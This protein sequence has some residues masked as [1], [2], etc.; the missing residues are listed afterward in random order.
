MVFIPFIPECHARRFW[1]HHAIAWTRLRA[2]TEHDECRVEEGYLMMV[3]VH[4]LS[5]SPK[6][7][8][9]TIVG[10]ISGRSAMHIAPTF[11]ERRRNF[12]GQH[13]WARGYFVIVLGDCRI[14]G[15]LSSPCA[16]DPATVSAL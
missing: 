9:A 10:Y 6:Y 3:H 8:V 1:R 14:R 15:A 13:F 7:A 16:S 5:I 12:V 4:L 2:L 11:G